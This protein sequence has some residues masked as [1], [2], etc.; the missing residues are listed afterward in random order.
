MSSRQGNERHQGPH[1]PLDVFTSGHPYW[2]SRFERCLGM[3]DTQLVS[4]ASLLTHNLVYKQHIM[5][6]LDHTHPHFCGA[7]PGGTHREILDINRVVWSG[8]H[9]HEWQVENTS[10]HSDRWLKALSGVRSY[11]KLCALGSRRMCVQ[12]CRRTP[13]TGWEHQQG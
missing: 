13:G 8:D 11:S 3:P 2:F 9:I 6:M 4:T 1:H 5:S 10:G 7:Q 12:N